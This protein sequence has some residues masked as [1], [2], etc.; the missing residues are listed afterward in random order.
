MRK[1]LNS[2]GQKGF[3]L[4]ELMIVVAILGIL[5]AVAIPAFVKYMRR[6]K[7]TEAE[8][9]LAYLFRA[10]TTYYTAERPARGTGG[11]VAVLCIP[12]SAGPDPG[13]A[14]QDRRTADLPGLDSTWSSLDFQIADPFYYDY[15]Y[16]GA[17]AC[18]VRDADAFTAAAIG[19]LDGDGNTSLFERAARANANAEIEGS[20]GLYVL[21]ETE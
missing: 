4:I 21:N 6:S 12:A 10:S 18:D 17:G 16:T 3:T 1:L 14:N 8:D 7:T 5:A 2:K 15:Q 9:K 20:K 13:G 19:D 11:G